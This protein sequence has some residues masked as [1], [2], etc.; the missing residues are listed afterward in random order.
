MKKASPGDEGFFCNLPTTLSTAS[1]L[2]IQIPALQF[3]VI[4]KAWSHH[5]NAVT[6]Q[7]A[8]LDFHGY[9]DAY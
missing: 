9:L 5:D 2:S 6:D 8:Q 4:D 3:V 7:P 1:W